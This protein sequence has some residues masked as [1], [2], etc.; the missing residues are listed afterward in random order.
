MPSLV[1]LQNSD[2]S[3]PIGMQQ[4]G[5]NQREV[6]DAVGM[7]QRPMNRLRSSAS[8]RSSCSCSGS[9]APQHSEA[10]PH[11]PNP[12]NTSE[13]TSSRLNP[14]RCHD[15]GTSRDVAKGMR[16][17]RR[18]IGTKNLNFG[19]PSSSWWIGRDWGLNHGPCCPV[20]DCLTNSSVATWKKTTGK[21]EN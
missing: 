21:T 15:C 20:D 14:W 12:G 16:L 2:Q 13:Q 19:T 11:R 8:S 4:G 1:R 6:A 10:L 5:M 3:S 9:E 17:P 18:V 7:S